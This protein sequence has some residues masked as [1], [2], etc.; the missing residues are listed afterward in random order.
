[1]STSDA[2]ALGALLITLLTAYVTLAPMRAELIVCR[3]ER[4]EMRRRLE[5][6]T[7]AIIGTLPR[8]Q[9]IELLVQLDE[10]IA[11]T[12]GGGSI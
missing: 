6:I 7:A 5:L 11:P 2:I 9:R 1:M 8:E 3:R 10:R 4:L 12:N